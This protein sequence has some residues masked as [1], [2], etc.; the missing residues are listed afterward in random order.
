ML[1]STLSGDFFVRK[2]YRGIRPEYYSL[3]D[4][5]TKSQ[6]KEI[7]LQILKDFYIKIKNKNLPLLEMSLFIDVI[8]LLM[9]D[10][11]SRPTWYGLQKPHGYQCM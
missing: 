1:L 9:F 10:Q 7:F 5:N 6:V 8:V 4:S 2:Q 11:T 3:G